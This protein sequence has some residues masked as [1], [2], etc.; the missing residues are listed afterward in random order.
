[1]SIRLYSGYLKGIEDQ[2]MLSNEKKK[3]MGN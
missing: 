1:M 2:L 3:M